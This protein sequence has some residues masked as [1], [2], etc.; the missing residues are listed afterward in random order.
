MKTLSLRRGFTLI[1]LLV[2]I[3]IIALLMAL[4]LPAVQKVRAAAD[5]LRCGNNLKQ[6]GIASHNFHNDYG[7]LPPA[8][9]GNNAHDPDGWATWAVLLLPYI[10][11]DA[12]YK[13]WRLPNL[14][15]TQPPGAY[16]QQIKTYL[17]PARPS[18]RLSINDG[19]PGGGLSD[20]AACFGTDADHHRSN[21]AIIPNVP[22]M[23]GGSP[24]TL[25][26][27]WKGQFKITDLRDGSTHTMMFG[28]KH[29]RPNSM[30]PTRGR[31]EDR[32]IFAGHN[33][34]IRRM[35]GIGM[36]DGVPNG[37]IRPLRPPHDQTGALANSSF[38]GPH[39]GSCQ[40]VMGDGSVRSF[41]TSIDLQP[42]SYLIMRAD[43]NVV[44]E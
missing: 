36:T 15:S 32:S 29:I 11:Q 26:V 33:N 16:E 23:G 30:R 18:P 42:L 8:W 7:V 5:K 37:D 19:V 31:N 22:N 34:S 14:A 44:E 39:P 21:G 2:V 38:G 17:C 9:I 25:V 10:E 6:L 3:A 12:P 1:E 35:A 28:E 24:P 41:A 20:Y 40:F 13:L 27:T 43:G 4:L